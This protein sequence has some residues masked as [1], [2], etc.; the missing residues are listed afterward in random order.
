MRVIPEMSMLADNVGTSMPSLT[1]AY[2]HPQPDPTGLPGENVGFNGDFSWEMISLG[3]EEPL[4]TQ[5]VVDELY[6]L[7]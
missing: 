6:V 1:G 4:P 2:G 3:L 5:D 7:L